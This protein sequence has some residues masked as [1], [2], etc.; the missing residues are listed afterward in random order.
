[1]FELARLGWRNLWRNPRRSA[2]TAGGIGVAVFLLMGFMAMQ[3]G[4]Y[5]IMRETA[6]TLQTGH[7]QI[8]QVDWHDAARQQDT[9]TGVAALMERLQALPDVVNVAPR[10]VAFTLLSAGERSFGAQLYGLDAGRE[11]CCVQLLRF[12][13]EGRA[14]A[15]GDEAVPGRVL[16]RNLGV[17]TGDELI[18]LGTRFDGVRLGEL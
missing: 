8:Q 18:L 2:L 10:F 11:A 14:P 16:A 3:A 15:A 12:I 9:V 5:D 13:A 4:Q 6:A 17:Q 7:L 1:M